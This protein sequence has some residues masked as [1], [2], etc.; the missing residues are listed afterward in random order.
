MKLPPDSSASRASTTGWRP[1]VISIHGSLA[2]VGACQSSVSERSA[3]AHSASSDASARGQPREGGHVRLQLVEHLLVEPFLPGQGALLRTERLVFKRL[4]L[5]REET[6]G[7]LQRLAPP[8]V[9]RYLVE[10]ALRHLDVEPVDL[11]EL[12]PQVGDAGAGAFA[13]FQVEQ[14]AVAVVLDGA[15]LVQLGVEA[16]GDHAALA[17]QRGG[18]VLHRAGQQGRATGRGLHI[19]RDLGQKCPESTSNIGSLVCFL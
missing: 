13:G 8:V 4:E 14:K 17:H 10:L 12:H 9:G 2:K 18:F 19:G 3:S 1:R 7:V 5:G 6:L 15:Q 11:V 16:G